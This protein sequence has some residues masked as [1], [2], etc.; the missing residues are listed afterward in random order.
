MTHPGRLQH[1]ISFTDLTYWKR[2]EDNKESHELARGK[3]SSI[4][5]IAR[6]PDGIS[7]FHYFATNVK[8]LDAVENTLSS[9]ASL[10]G[11]DSD[12]RYSMLPLLFLHSDPA[13]NKAGQKTTPIHL[14]LDRQ[15]PQSFE[16]MLGLLST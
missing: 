12:A 15:S 16:I 4:A 14:A 3:L 8:V 6:F 13:R 2:Y 7:V 5:P 10:G 11:A 9:R 1:F